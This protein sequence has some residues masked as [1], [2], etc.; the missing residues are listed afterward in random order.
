MKKLISGLLAAVSALTMSV[1]VCAASDL[2]PT[3]SFDSEKYSPYVH[4]FGNAEES[5]LTMELSE[6]SYM[7]YSLLLK[8][9]FTEGISNQY[10]G[11]YFDASDFGISDF[12]GYT[13]V[14]YIK[15]A[16]N[17]SKAVSRFELFTDGQ[18]WQ[19]KDIAVSETGIFTSY[20]ISVP[21]NVKNT[22]FGISIPITDPYDGEVLYLDNVSIVDNYGKEIANIGD[23][24]EKSLAKAPPTAVTVLTTILFVILILAAIAGVVLFAIKV[25]RSYR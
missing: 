19:S 5:N 12:G 14:A 18:K 15:P 6:D 9:S 16:E 21:Q 22:K 3:V 25:L 8:E 1:S 23:F 2:G 17:V 20:S 13:F 11:I 7:G 24:A 10:G 4:T